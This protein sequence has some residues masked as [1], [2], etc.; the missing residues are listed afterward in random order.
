M[1]PTIAWRQA[2]ARLPTP[3]RQS[4][5][6]RKR[7]GRT[8]SPE[9]EGVGMSRDAL[10]QRPAKALIDQDGGP[11]AGWRCTR[12]AKP[13]GSADGVEAS[14]DGMAGT[15]KASA[16]EETLPCDMSAQ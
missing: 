10:A 4:Y 3:E 8:M 2:G 11:R 6:A 15:E 13:I 9:I 12:N 7:A 1:W 16:P 14:A 5:R